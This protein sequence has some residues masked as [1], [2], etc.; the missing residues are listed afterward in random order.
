[1][2]SGKCFGVCYD[3]DNGVVKIDCLVVVVWI[4]GKL[5]GCIFG[6]IDY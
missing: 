1:M 3:S 4:N 5:F 2:F 6:N